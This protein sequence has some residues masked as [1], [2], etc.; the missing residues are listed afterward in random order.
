MVGGAGRG[1]SVFPEAAA[2]GG[3]KGN[4][5]SGEGCLLTIWWGRPGLVAISG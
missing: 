4:G 3:E 2:I 5:E 1:G